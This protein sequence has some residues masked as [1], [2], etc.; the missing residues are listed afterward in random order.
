M[1]QDYAEGEKWYR[2]SAEQGDSEA[3][4]NLGCI[5]SDGLGVENDYKEALK[6]F[7][8]SALH[9]N[10]MGQLNLGLMYRDGHGVEKDHDEA[11][12]WFFRAAAEKELAKLRSE[13]SG[14][15]RED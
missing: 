6:W 7:R 15:Y 14:L 4:N 13:S 2:K 12:K 8:K 11:A 5:Y 3:E 9:G 1:P 10:A